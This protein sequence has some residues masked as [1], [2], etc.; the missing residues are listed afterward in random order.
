[1]SEETSN[2]GAT[3]LQDELIMCYVSKK[4]VPLS[5]TVEVDYGNNKKYRVLPK[6]IKY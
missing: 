1:M 4:M 3:D 6:Y 5:E 2:T